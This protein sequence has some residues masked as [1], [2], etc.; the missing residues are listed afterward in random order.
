[1]RRASSLFI[2]IFVAW[3]LFAAP[4]A[5]D[6]PSDEIAQELQST[7]VYVDPSIEDAAAIKAKLTRR[8]REDDG[9]VVA[10]LAA[11]TS[12]SAETVAQQIASLLTEP[13]TVV[14]TF[15]QS[16]A[17]AATDWPDQVTADDI[18]IRSSS[19]TQNPVDRMLTFVTKVHDWQE[20]NPRP[21]P[22]SPPVVQD[23]TGIYVGTGAA[24]GVAIAL[25][26]AGW[27]IVRRNRGFSR[28]YSAPSKYRKELSQLASFADKHR[29]ANHE[30]A[31]T[32][33][34]LCKD[35]SHLFRN[36]SEVGDKE[37]ISRH[38]ANAVKVMSTYDTVNQNP[39]YYNG[40]A[41]LLRE[42]EESIADLA[43]FILDV[44]RGE[45]SDTIN[46]Y[47]VNVAIV[48]DARNSMIH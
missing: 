21:L 44:A 3:L 26:A 9:L 45:N 8:I 43:T 38:L 48:N 30:L 28:V 42:G 6:T 35:A 31:D 17:V 11:D 1:M 7:S 2:V 25:G 33:D 41:A 24:A 16:G 5:A 37:L 23:N 14:V 19:V 18:M 22:P 47:K 27:I 12:S 46:N 4:A 20:D 32:L 15:A 34:Q 36:R 10:I 13:S 39:R 40:S 29:A